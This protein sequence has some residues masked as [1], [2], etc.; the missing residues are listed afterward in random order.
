[1]N[2]EPLEKVITPEKVFDFLV[3]FFTSTQ[4]YYMLF[5][6]FVIAIC[7]ELYAKYYTSI[8]IKEYHEHLKTMETLNEKT[9]H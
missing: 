1:M 9:D 7:V 8:K 2:Y 4:F 5:F 6:F 3:I